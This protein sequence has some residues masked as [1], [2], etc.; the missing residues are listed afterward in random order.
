MEGLDLWKSRWHD[1]WV[2]IL[3]T[4]AIA[5]RRRTQPP[6]TEEEMWEELRVMLIRLREERE[7]IH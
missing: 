5:K 4:I 6:R 3:A 7:N 2:L 1:R